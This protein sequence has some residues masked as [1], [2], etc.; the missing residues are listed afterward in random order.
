MA[1][2]F[3]EQYQHSRRYFVNLGKITQKK[4][5]QSLAWLSL[6]LLTITFF[7][8]AAI[9]PTLVTIARLN[10]EIKDKKAAS[11]QLQNKINSL[12]AAQNT[13]TKNVDYLPLL[14]AALPAKNQFPQLAYFFEEAAS[15]TGVIIKNVAFEKINVTPETSAKA[16]A[17]GT[18]NTF[19]FTVIANGDYFGLSRFLQSLESSRRIIMINSTSF[20]TSKKSDETSLT[21]S[22]SG[23]VFFEAK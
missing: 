1:F 12:I 23:Q 17:Q 2:D 8:M 21:L 11:Q 7:A 16:K 10:R 18:G 4:Q 13:Y 19:L 15:S 22:L 6:T 9:R 3:Y 20:G 5:V 14:E